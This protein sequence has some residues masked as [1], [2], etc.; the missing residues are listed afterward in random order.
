MTDFNDVMPHGPI[1]ELFPDVF[2]VTGTMKA[3]FF[4]SDWQFSRNMTVVREGET[5]TL[6]NAVRL[7]E[8]G[9]AALE[10]LGKVTHVVRLGALHGHDDAFYVDRYGATYWSVAGA[11]EIPGVP[12]DKVLGADGALPFEASLF[13]F[14][15][16]KLPEAVL[17][18]DREGG[19]MLSCDAL[20]N[21]LEPDEFF[22]DETRQKMTDM[23]FFKAHNVGVAWAHVNEPKAEDFARL[24]EISFQHALCGHGAPAIDGA[25]AGYHATWAAMFEL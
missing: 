4:G 18:L 6:L 16:T 23:G 2:F 25:Q 15:A 7:D 10:K 17:R 13:E 12:V 5:L 14:K 1:Q 8:A 24:K 11:P 3:E 21:Y 20:Q 22:D 19:I 9:L